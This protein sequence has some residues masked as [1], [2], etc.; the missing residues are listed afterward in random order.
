VPARARAEIEVA[1]GGEPP[2]GAVALV[3]G[4]QAIVSLRTL[5][6]PPAAAREA[7][8][9]ATGGAPSSSPDEVGATPPSP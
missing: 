8:E 4:A 1:T 7:P 9:P 2:E 5:G 6:A 3:R